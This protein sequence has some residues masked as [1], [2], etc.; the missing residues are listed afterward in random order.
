MTPSRAILSSPQDLIRTLQDELAETNREALALTVELEKRMAERAAELHAA[1]EEL[2]HKNER[3]E[4]VNQELQT[5]THAISHELRGPLR[6]LQSFAAILEDEFGSALGEPGNDYLSR[7]TKIAQEME[8]LF[9]Q[10]IKFALTG[11]QRMERRSVDFNR[12]VREVIADLETE[13]TSRR[14]EWI[15]AS[16]PPVMGDE[17]MLH[18][19]WVN[20]ISN[21]FKY[22]RQNPNP[23]IE[24]GSREDAGGQRVFFVRDNG[25]GFDMAT[26]GKLF[27]IFER[28]HPRSEFEG[29]GVGLALVRRIVERHGGRI[30]AESAV[31]KGATFYFSLP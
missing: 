21:A 5:F 17:V 13:T 19:V 1:Q 3:L 16:L 7:L 26:A 6:H 29:S 2:Q 14:V 15:V 10:L 25:V 18:Q 8:V 22:T 30:W 9:D 23:R 4:A 27:D 31:G 11:Q 28:L 20:L 24:I 12:L